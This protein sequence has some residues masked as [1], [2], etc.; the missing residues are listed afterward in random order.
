MLLYDFLILVNKNKGLIHFLKVVCDYDINKFN[1][2]QIKRK[3]TSGCFIAT[4]T[5][6][7]PLAEEVFVLKEWRDNYLLKS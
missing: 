5:Y 4:A 2:N 6:G 7:S 3:V 1:R